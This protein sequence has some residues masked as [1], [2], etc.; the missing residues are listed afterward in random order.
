MIR[1]DN[2]TD[3]G[4]KIRS[5]VESRRFFCLLRIFRKIWRIF[6]EFFNFHF[7]IR[8]V[9]NET[10]S[11]RQGR[12][13]ERLYDTN[14]RLFRSSSISMPPLSREDEQHWEGEA[15]ECLQREFHVTRPEMTN[16]AEH[17]SPEDNGSVCKKAA[18]V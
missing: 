10:L 9:N 16:Y 7:F 13:I 1:I 5:L 17:L 3:I 11:M 6:R 12:Q 14:F 4:V 2:R 15:E 8:G 18:V